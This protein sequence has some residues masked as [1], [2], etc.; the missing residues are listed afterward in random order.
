MNGWNMGG[1]MSRGELRSPIP[2]FN[3]GDGTFE[4]LGCCLVRTAVRVYSCL[5]EDGIRVVEQ[6]CCFW[7]PK[8]VLLY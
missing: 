8:S 5:E 7:K 1:S 6:V 3:G 2:S 4:F